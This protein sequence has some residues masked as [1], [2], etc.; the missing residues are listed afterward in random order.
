MKQRDY[1]IDVMKGFACILMI[2]AHTQFKQPSVIISVLQFIGNLAPIL[3]FA[4][5]G[6]TTTFQAKSKNSLPI[7]IFYIMLAL[8]GLSFD[9]IWRP[10]LWE[11]P[12][13]E[14]LQI[15]AIGSISVTL[16]EKYLKPEKIF[17]MLFSVLIFLVHYLFTR[18]FDIQ[19]FPFEQF[20]FCGKL[21]GSSFP[22][23][24]WLMTFF[25]GIFAYYSQNHMNLVIGLAFLVTL[26][27]FE[28]LGG[29]D[30]TSLPDKWNMSVEYLLILYTFLFLSFY[31]FRSIKNYSP[32]NIFIYFGQYSLL[33][34]YVH[35][36]FI[37]VF[38][39]AKLQQP[40]FVWISIFA[41]SYL[42]M[43]LLQYANKYLEKY[44]HNYSIWLGMIVLICII[45]IITTNGKI[46]LITE[47]FLGI[48][49]ANNYLGLSKLIKNS[50]E[51]N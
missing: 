51:G 29:V 27:G 48:L 7:I 15:I 37:K 38:E 6:V 32:N 45:P 19:P 50:F 49:F 46:I 31:I 28:C 8:L 24:P 25:A 30:L 39:L 41:L 14:I 34:L 9:A 2:L 26:I 17:Y 43:K 4:V 11:I 36:I 23:F 42:L 18:V 3:F 22:I 33:F 35:M 21:S 13:C 12:L 1:S 47:T 5:S 20:L 10:N 16:I 40:Y 44:F